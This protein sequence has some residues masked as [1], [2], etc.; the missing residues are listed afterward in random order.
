MIQGWRYQVQTPFSA[1]VVSV[2]G[3]RDLEG[4]SY[5]RRR[6]V[7]GVPLPVP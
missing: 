4:S 7:A 6:W 1:L 5:H 2:V 3:H